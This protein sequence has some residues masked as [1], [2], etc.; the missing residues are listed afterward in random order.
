MAV[1]IREYDWSRT[2]LGS[3]ANWTESFLTAVN[4]M[5]ASPNTFAL[6]CGAGRILLLYND[7]YRPL[8]HAKHPHALGMEGS[9]VWKE[10]WHVIGPQIEAARIEGKTTSAV[11]VLIPIQAEHGMR[12]GWFSYSFHPVYG[13]DGIIA[14]G[15]PGS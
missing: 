15:N 7:A 8:L 2:P 4:I 14:V 5:L 6:Y 12:D 11:E 10:A 3:L 1:R 9:E 13:P